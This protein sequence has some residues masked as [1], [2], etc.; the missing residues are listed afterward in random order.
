M[1][2]HAHA[3]ILRNQRAKKPHILTC[4]EKESGSQPSACGKL[5][6]VRSDKGGQLQIERGQNL[7]EESEAINAK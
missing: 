1:P 6:R 2:C 7:S 4:H 5:R 3:I